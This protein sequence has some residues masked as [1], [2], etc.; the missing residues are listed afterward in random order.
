M[1]T[2]IATQKAD[3]ATISAVLQQAYAKEATDREA[4]F[5]RNELAMRDQ[6]DELRSDMDGKAKAALASLEKS[7]NDAAQL[8]GVVGNIGVTG[9]Y[10]EI[11]NKED[12]AAGKWRLMTLVFF[13]F[14]IALAVGT[15]IEFWKEPVTAQNAW[16]VA[17]R[18]LYAIAL[19][20]P[21]WYTAKESA[22]HRTNS[23]RARQRELELASLG[24]FIELLPQP[25]KEEIR[26]RMTKL[27]FG[28]EVEEHQSSPPIDSKDLKDVMIELIKAIKK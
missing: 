6:F 24:P 11:A 2:T 8:A 22:R 9:N 28:K 20:A 15:F 3:A 4:A 16:A 27:Y 7:K 19:A 12:K 21:A 17:I 14:G 13:G 18:L 1:T 26:E 10:Q 23:D 5:H 25:K